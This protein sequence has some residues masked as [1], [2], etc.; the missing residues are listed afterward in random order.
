MKYTIKQFQ[1]D[2]PDDEACLSY[3]FAHRFGEDYP[4][5]ECGKTSWYKVTGRKAYA[6][7]SGHFINPLADTIFHKSDTKLSLWFFA[8][9]KFSNSRNG[10]SAKELERDLGV[11]Y[12]TAWRI[13]KKI[14]S[15]MDTSE[16]KL[17][18]TVEVDEA[19]MEKMKTPHSKGDIPKVLGMVQRQGGA[20]AIVMQKTGTFNTIP[21][22]KSEVEAGSNLM[23]DMAAVYRG[24]KL[25]DYNHNAVNHSAKQ[26]VQGLIHTNTVEGF[27]SQ[28]KRSID[29]TYHRVSQK[30][31]QSY[32]DEFSWRLSHARSGVPLFLLLLGRLCR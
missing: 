4:C 27:F 21:L 17:S 19:Y 2:F 8:V 24:K 1:K 29:G 10:V 32:L 28:I 23:T 12:K 26:F 22:I 20:K 31:L 30:Y 13:A 25:D 18:G 7:P 9:Y 16:F 3:V 5:P 6:C 11:T 14:R 15:L